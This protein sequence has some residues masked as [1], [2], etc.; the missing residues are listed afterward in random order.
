MQFWQ[1]SSKQE[2]IHYVLKS[3]HLII[4]FG[5][6]NNYHSRE[7]NLLLYLFLKNVIN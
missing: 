1:N 6:R 2:V 5:I 7:R 3:T 4:P